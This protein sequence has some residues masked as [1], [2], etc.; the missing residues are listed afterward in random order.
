MAV[1][2]MSPSTRERQSLLRLTI[3]IRSEGRQGDSIVELLSSNHFAFEAAGSPNPLGSGG[4]LAE[5]ER[6]RASESLLMVSDP[7]WH[8]CSLPP[9]ANVKTPSNVASRRISPA[10]LVASTTSPR[11]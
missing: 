1:T 7:K 3:R 2:P 9:P 6:N 11:P 10:S 5:Y 8:V 4:G